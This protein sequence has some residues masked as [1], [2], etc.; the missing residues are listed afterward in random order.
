ME[1]I[2]PLAAIRAG[3]SLDRPMEVS[4]AWGIGAVPWL[5]TVR[6]RILFVT[7]GRINSGHDEYQFGLGPVLETLADPS[8]AWW[9]TFETD[10][11]VRDAPESFRFTQDGFDIDDYDEIFF[12]G[13]WPGEASNN[14]EF[15]DSLIDRPEYWPLRDEELRVVAEW[16]DRGGG[17]FAA[18]DHALLGASMCRR[19]PRVRSM[20]RWTRAQ[21]VPAFDGPHRHETLQHIDGGMTWW[22]GDE[23]AQRIYPVLRHDGRRPFDLFDAYPHP[24]LCGSQGVIDHFPDHM[25][26]GSVYENDEVVLDEPLDIPGYEGVEYPFVRP[27][28]LAAAVS[29][30][31]EALGI[32]PR[33]EVVAH[34]M[35]TNPDPIT[36]PDP[37][38]VLVMA[39][40][41][42]AFPGKKF[43]VVGAYDGDPA[44][45]GRVVVDSTWHHWFS[46]N[47]AGFQSKAP[48]RYRDMQ[49]YYR[50]VALWLARPHQRAGMLFAATWGLAVGKYP[51]A[52]DREL[53]IWGNGARALDAI[54]RTASRCI[55][56][57]LVATVLGRTA[58]TLESND[59]ASELAKS[60]MLGALVDQAVLGGIMYGQLPAARDHVIEHARGNTT[61]VDPAQVGKGATAGLEDG[62]NALVSALAD[63][64]A[65]LEALGEH[66]LD[67]ARET[68]ASD[69]VLQS[70]EPLPRPEG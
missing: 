27:Q 63:E 10:F 14:P 28:V 51:G 59:P 22:E 20:R 50:N 21:R 9:V 24:L 62:L 3:G 35:T 70:L 29:G 58:A 47:L 6:V 30:E 44:G 25:H 38:G 16:M 68:H 26:E 37:V 32:R 49:S 52:F 56:S 34:A 67:L 11:V 65:S 17:V 55:V 41:L 61:T 40:R 54:G 46:M 8:F 19:I 64:A 60:P 18:G 69:A 4:R 1:Q 31:P 66:L 43:P 33:P 36:A 48:A 5:C 53:G 45:V 13:D 42:D 12:F 2:E 15:P 7:D 23:W 57:E 39:R